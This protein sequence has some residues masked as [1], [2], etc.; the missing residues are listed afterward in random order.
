LIE[1]TYRAIADDLQRKIEAGELKPGQQL[2]TEVVLR[3]DYGGVSR[4]TVRD[5]LKLLTAHGLIETRHGRGTFVV[6]KI[7]PFVS[8]LTADPAAGGV[9]DAIYASE[10][11]RQQREPDGSRPRVE[12]QI[13][14]PE[15]AQLLG[16]EADAD[17]QVVSRYQQRFIDGTPYSTQVTYY[18]MEFVAKGATRLLE[19]RDFDEG[20]VE[21]LR[22][23]GIDQTSWRDLF[24]LRSADDS[25]RSIF[26]LSDQIQVAVLEVRRT[27]YDQVGRP[28]RVTVTV[29]AG[30]RNQLELE[31]GDPPDPPAVKS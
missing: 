4:S 23:C 20:V 22:S 9:E 13:P 17:A 3:E 28:M 30:D 24:S 21:Y 16:L 1:P 8:K 29:Y 25:E 7:V 15:L 31:A 6:Q 10:V 27:G 19:A 11:K 12:V 2:P 14:S 26:G 18:P 5:A